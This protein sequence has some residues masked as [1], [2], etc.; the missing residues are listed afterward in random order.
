MSQEEILQTAPKIEERAIQLWETLPAF[1]KF[2][3]LEPWDT[4]RAPV[5]LMFL[6][7]IR[8][9]YLGHHFLL[10]RTLIKKVGAD[11][12]KLLSIARQIFDYVL[13]LINNRDMLREYQID[14]SQILCMYGI[15][16]AAV[17][18]V[19]LLHQEQ[20]PSVAAALHNRL[21][22]SDTIQGLSVLVACLSNVGREWG[23]H[24]I[25]V[26]GKR[27]LKKIIDTILEPPPVTGAGHTAETSMTA[28][29][30]TYDDFLTAPLFQTGS[31]S[32]F[33]R[34]LDSMDGEQDSW[35]YF[36]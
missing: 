9:D 35:V 4:K 18:A 22:R 15:P 14:I 6:A 25:M 36:T 29:D 16:S 32:D 34:W 12:V 24:A 31:D 8:L 13:M 2:D 10:Q 3:G 7:Y 21:P 33:L 23:A 20:D 5:E 28:V 19:E 27:F 1:L 30:A 26:R 17:V 11:S